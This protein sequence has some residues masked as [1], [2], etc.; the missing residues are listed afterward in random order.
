MIIEILQDIPTPSD[1][2][3]LAYSVSILVSVVIF[4]VT[5]FTGREKTMKK[6]QDDD[7][8]YIREQD[9]ENIK[10]ITEV[11]G[12]LREVLKQTDKTLDNVAQSKDII[13]E[14]NHR[15]KDIQENMKR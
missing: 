1:K 13:K 6:E 12:I 4:L 5:Y 3:Y 14:N 11:N 2:K 8:Q 9:K 10:L 7:K 15:L